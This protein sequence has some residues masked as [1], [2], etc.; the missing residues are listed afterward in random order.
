MKFVQA[1]LL[2]NNVINM[3]FDEFVIETLSVI[4]ECDFT[5]TP[6]S[7]IFATK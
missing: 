7:D 4:F 5:S 1:A 6:K 2:A 3:I